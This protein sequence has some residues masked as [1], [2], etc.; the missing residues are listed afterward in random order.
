MGRKS[1][2]LFEGIAL[3]VTAIL[4]SGVLFISGATASVAGPAS[5][6]SWAVVIILSFPLAYTFACL[7]RQFPDAGGT[8]TF[9]RLSFGYHLGNLVG[10]FYFVCA[11]IGQTIVSLTGA[12]YVVSAF[13]LSQ[14][15]TVIMALIILLV[16][17]VTNYF[18]LR[19]SGK[20]ALFISG[21]LLILLMSVILV[22]L[23]RIDW[24]QFVPFNPFGWS[25]VGTA[26]TMILWSFFGWEAICNLSNQF[27]NPNNDI[28]KS[29]FISAV[30][31]GILFLLLS[32]TTIGTGTYGSMESNLSPIGVM[33]EQTLGIGAKVI[34]AFL[35]FII[36]TGTVNAF[37][38]SIAQLGYSLSRDGAFPKW[39][40]AVDT[41]SNSPRRA[42]LFATVIA[43]FG[44]V[45]TE[46]INITFYDILFIPTSLGLVVY[47][48]SM[49]SGVKLFKRGTLPWLTSILSFILC[50]LILPF[51]ELFIS[52]P[53]G[54]AILY[55]LYMTMSKGNEHRIIHK[56]SF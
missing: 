22:N 21:C 13:N 30:I 11:T 27:K 25:A 15:Y 1:I 32:F 29:T 9:V 28:V 52:V 34:T 17:G 5:L 3:Y 51:F 37:L 45:I 38:A 53:I 55:I 43:G 46:I 12:F 33:M 23:P 44:V 7:S 42:I 20:V 56:S 31:I 8:A 19:I 10:W 18:G 26:V 24:N 50:I 35:A 6:M 41:I 48:L 39:F 40:V 14:I 36:C 49:A 4:G 2:G 54:V 47:I 16:G